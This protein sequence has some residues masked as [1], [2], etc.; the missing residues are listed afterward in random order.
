MGAAVVGA[1]ASKASADF[2]RPDQVARYSFYGRMSAGNYSLRSGA[3]QNT[4]MDVMR[5][6]SSNVN[7]TAHNAVI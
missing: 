6:C 2:R 1:T 4:R 7:T 3:D 5:A